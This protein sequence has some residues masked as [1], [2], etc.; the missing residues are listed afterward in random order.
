MNYEERIKLLKGK[1]EELNTLK[2]KT[3]TQLEEAEKRRDEVIEEMK[4]HEVTPK[5]I[6]DHI[7]KLETKIEADL[8]ALEES[9]EKIEDELDEAKVS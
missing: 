1:L 4:E 3:E 9:V 8:S 2:V 7:K 5:T 6:E